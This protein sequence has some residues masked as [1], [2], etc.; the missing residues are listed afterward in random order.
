MAVASAN[1]ERAAIL[2]ATIVGPRACLPRSSLRAQHQATTKQFAT[3]FLQN[4][5]ED[6]ANFASPSL[7]AADAAREGMPNRLGRC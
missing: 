2:R 4:F 6:A 3:V 1:D 5:Q 7:V